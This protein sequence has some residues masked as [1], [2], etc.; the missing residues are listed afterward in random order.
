MNFWWWSGP[1]GCGKTTLLKMVAGLL[2]PSSGE[3]RIEGRVVTKPHGDVGIVFQTAMLL[4]W[5]NV[6]RNVMM[7]VEVQGLTAQ[8]RTRSAPRR[9]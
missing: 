6:F 1:S 3:I 5:R 8:G 4:P 7:P 2:A 9:C